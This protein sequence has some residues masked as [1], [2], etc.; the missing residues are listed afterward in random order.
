MVYNFNFN[1][2][3]P[4]RYDLEWRE[5]K[6]RSEVKWKPDKT[7]KITQF[8]AITHGNH[9]YL[10]DLITCFLTC[11]FIFRLSLPRN[12]ARD[13][14]WKCP[15]PWSLTCVILLYFDVFSDVIDGFWI[16]KSLLILPYY[17]KW[18]TQFDLSFHSAQ[19]IGRTGLMMTLYGFN[20]QKCGTLSKFQKMTRRIQHIFSTL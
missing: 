18:N 9:Y 6:M 15:V 10:I 14:N 16:I 3:T 11:S 7:L 19:Y 20:I 12:F 2:I 1:I 4:P 8:S 5:M 17:I 13:L